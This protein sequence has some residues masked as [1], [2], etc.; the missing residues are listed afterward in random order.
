M[1]SIKHEDFSSNYDLFVKLCDITSE[2][3]RLTKEGSPDLVVMNQWLVGNPD[4][5]MKNW[6][7][8]DMDTNNKLD[9]FDLCLMRTALLSK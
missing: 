4:S 9:G 5:G 1:I 3:L 2:P 6:K 7:A 8:G